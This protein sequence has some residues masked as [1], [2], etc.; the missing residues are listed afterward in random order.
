MMVPIAQEVF[1]MLGG[2]GFALAAL[3]STVSTVGLGGVFVGLAWAQVVEMR[4]ASAHWRTP[5]ALYTFTAAV[6]V[7]IIG[8]IAVAVIP[9]RLRYREIIGVALFR[10]VWSSSLMV[11]FIFLIACMVLVRR[12]SGPGIRIMRIGAKIL[13]VTSLLGLIGIIAWLPGAPWYRS[14]VYS[15]QTVNAAVQRDSSVSQDVESAPRIAMARRTFAADD[16]LSATIPDRP[17]GLAQ[18]LQIPLSFT[19]KNVASISVAQYNDGQS[20]KNKSGGSSVGSGR[21]KVIRDDGLTKTIEIIPLQVGVLNVEVVATFEDGGIS[22]KSYQ[23]NVIPSAKGVR[24]FHL[25][26]GFDVFPIV[27]GDKDEDRPVSLSPEVYYDQ[28]D[29]PIYLTDSSQIKF[30][31]KQPDGEPVIRL[32]GN[33]MVHGLRPGIARIVGDFDGAQDSVTVQVYAREDASA[34][35]RGIQQLVP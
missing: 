5:V 16:R 11:S 9:L 17:V 1:E 2:L 24:K 35:H 7:D 32:D 3:F 13:L 10:V 4:A 25:N 12:E 29:Y 30:T 21:A 22:K 27:L 8:F 28:L 26:K 33:G 23:L 19:D 18:P 14:T 20:F 34:G 6:L 31:V 15:P